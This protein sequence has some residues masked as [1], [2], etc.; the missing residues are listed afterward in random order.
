MAIMTKIKN[1]FA[2]R[3]TYPE[4]GADGKW[5]HC[6]QEVAESD[7]PA[8]DVRVKRNRKWTGL[9]AVSMIAFS[10]VASLGKAENEEKAPVEKDRVTMT[11]DKP[12]AEKKTQAEAPKTVSKEATQKIAQES[13]KPATPTAE[14][15]AYQK[16]VA[17]YE[18][19]ID[20]NH[21]AALAAQDHV[22]KGPEPVHGDSISVLKDGKWVID[23]MYDQPTKSWVTEGTFN[24]LKEMR[25]AEAQKK[26]L[27][28]AQRQAALK[29]KVA[30]LEALR[31]AQAKA[32]QERLAQEK[33]D[34]EVVTTEVKISS[35]PDSEITLADLEKQMVSSCGFCKRLDLLILVSED[36]KQ[37]Q[38]VDGN[39]GNGYMRTIRMKGDPVVTEG[40]VVSEE[41]KARFKDDARL[42]S[43]QYRPVT[44][45]MDYE[46]DE[47]TKSCS[48]SRKAGYPEGA[49]AFQGCQ[50]VY[51]DGR[52]VEDNV[53]Y[54]IGRALS[55]ASFVDVTRGKVLMYDVTPVPTRDKGEKMEL[56]V[57][58][59][60]QRQMAQREAA[61][62]KV[63]AS[64]GAS[65]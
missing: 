35:Y 45:Y 37:C 64:R 23:T 2:E 40:C 6:G 16:K 50:V 47:Q 30:E 7:V 59:K 1:F 20:A 25:A 14:E 17:E 44:P 19:E 28:E 21:K 63:L 33:Y 10:A 60:E 27:A 54:Y 46:L 48:V 58:R 4:K 18:A 52:P 42:L 13:Q 39:G 9:T 41:E 3:L 22:E 65:K 36:G 43:V 26:L 57:T 55:K 51:P 31:V 34:N 49:T 61:Q 5:Y 29:A 62:K 38:L 8:I 12:V 24:K 11:A 53:D 32:E 56:Q 15:L